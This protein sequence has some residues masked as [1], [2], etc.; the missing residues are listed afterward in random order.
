MT[1]RLWVLKTENTNGELYFN[2]MSKLDLDDYKINILEYRGESIKLKSL[3]SQ[4]VTKGLILY[5][6]I[7]FLLYLLNTLAHDTKFFN[8]FIGFLTK[9]VAEINKEILKLI[10]WHVKN[11]ICN[12][13]ERLD[14]Y[15]WN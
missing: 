7:D 12:S 15:I 2:M 9:P 3:I 4:A 13:D 1:S 6:N 10:L 8:L 11:V 5:H 14:E